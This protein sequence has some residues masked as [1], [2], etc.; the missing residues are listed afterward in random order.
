MPVHILGGGVGDDIGAVLERTA[1]DGGR[2]S[3]VD[4]KRNAVRVCRGGEF[5]KIKD[6]QRRVGNRLA[7]DGFRVGLEGCVQFLY[8]AIGVDEGKGDTHTLQG[9]G[10]KVVGA[11]VE[12][13][14]AYDMIAAGSK[15]ED[16]KEGSRLPRRGKHSRRTALQLADFSRD[17]IAGGV[18][19]TGVEITARL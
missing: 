14:R 13:G 7:E 19:Q 11:A 17:G 5:L 9:D 1:V 15:V 6:G 2:E 16:G 18:L 8:G 3:V 4:N 10:E 12:C